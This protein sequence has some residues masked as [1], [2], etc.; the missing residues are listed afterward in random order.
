MYTRIEVYKYSSI[1]GAAGGAAAAEAAR[2]HRGEH[3]SEV[4]SPLAWWSVTATTCGRESIV[5]LYSIADD[6]T[7]RTL[8]NYYITV[9]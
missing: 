3:T 5:W 4:R 6:Y 9:V 8:Y 7:V 2:R 1:I